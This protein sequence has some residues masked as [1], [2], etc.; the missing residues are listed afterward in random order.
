M[1]KYE[2]E[3]CPALASPLWKPAPRRSAVCEWTLVNRSDYE[4]LVQAERLDYEKLV[5]S[6]ICNWA[7]TFRRSPPSCRVLHRLMRRHQQISHSLNA[8][9]EV[10][11]TTYY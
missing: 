2:S 11:S 10:L 5:M 9:A 4:R 8:T 7:C 6:T 3:I 1:C